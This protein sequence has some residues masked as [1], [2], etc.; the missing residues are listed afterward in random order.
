MSVKIY[1]TT[2]GFLK[3]IKATEKGRF[4]G[5]GCTDNNYHFTFFYLGANSLKYL[6]FSKRFKNKLLPIAAALLACILAGKLTTKAIGIVRRI[7]IIRKRKIRR[8]TGAA[9]LR[10]ACLPQEQAHRDISQ[11]IR[12]C[13]PGSEFTL[14]I[15]QQHPSL[16]LSEAAVFQAWKKHTDA[17]RIVICASCRTDPVV[18][19]F[20]ASLPAPKIIL[21]DSDMLSQ[22]IAEYPEGM[23]PKSAPKAPMRLRHA[24]NLLINRKNAP[25][26]LLFSASMLLMY[27]LTSNIFYIISALFLL[28]IAF[29]S[30]R[31]K[32]RPQKLF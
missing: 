30:L 17:D 5:A 19:A 16:K 11:L 28:I 20:S 32:L 7:P 15:I 26:N 8:N 9:M 21:I 27:F 18:R 2:R 6:Y 29:L 13:Y 4:S 1:G 23:I 25:R 3:T 10:I 12:K 31:R 14:E 22:M 24:A